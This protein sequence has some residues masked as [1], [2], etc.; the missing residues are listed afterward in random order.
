MGQQR[1]DQAQRLLAEAPDHAR[2]QGLRGGVARRALEAAVDV[3]A[4][5]ARAGVAHVG[6]QQRALLGLQFEAQ[7]WKEQHLA[8]LQRRAP[9]VIALHGLPVAAL[10]TD[11]LGFHG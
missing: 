5:V 4:D 7:A 11:D 1:I 2:Q 8:G 6:T 9:G 3:Q 10:D